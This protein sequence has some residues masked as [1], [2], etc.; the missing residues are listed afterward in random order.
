[1]IKLE[2]AIELAIENAIKYPAEKISLDNTPGKV[3]AED[4]VSDTDM[5]PFNKS[6]M[7]GFACRKG[8]IS[9]S[10]EI[11]ET[12]PAGR[13]PEKKIQPGTCSRIMTGAPVPDGADCV[14]MVEYTEEV[15]KDRIRFTGEM[16][17]HNIC[18]RGEDIKKGDVLLRKGLI[19]GSAEIAVMASAGYS[20]VSV[21]RQPV[22]GIAATGNELYPPGQELPEGAIRDSNSHQLQA[23]V[24]ETGLK[25]INRGIVKDTR[26]EISSVLAELGKKT[27]VI[28]LTGGVSV[29]DFDLV[30]EQLEKAGYRK[31]FHKVAIKPGMPLWFGLKN[32]IYCFG[33][34]GN[35]VSTFV[36]FE[37]VIKPFL[38]ALMG[39]EFKSLIIEMPLLKEVKR[40]KSD[41]DSIIPVRVLKDGVSPI[42]YHGSAHINAIPEAEGFIMLRA[43][44]THLKKGEKI[45]VR[46]L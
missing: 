44:T 33:L 26:E 45:D 17:H 42:E 2:K 7:D 25:T 30:P 41:R 38:Y 43:G 3:L 11:I 35:P 22:V 8:D 21:S 14:I 29:G 18:F 23:Q 10:L 31:I 32:G 39:A 46:L 20:R 1:M 9:S 19:I 28:L 12:I 37:Y 36:Q 40:K 4:I 5:P 15:G 13:L 16:I 24:R 34:P 27:D 6:A